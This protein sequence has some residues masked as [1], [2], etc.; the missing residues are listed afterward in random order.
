MESLYQTVLLLFSF[1]TREI[2]KACLGFVK[3]AISLLPNEILIANIGQTVEDVLP[4]IKDSQA[5]F[6]P[7]I[8]LI[9][10]ILIRRIG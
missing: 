7:K 9:F 1:R 2:V 6:R 3:S 4:W 8:K 10:E 5:R